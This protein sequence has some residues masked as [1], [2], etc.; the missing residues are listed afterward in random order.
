MTHWQRFLQA[1]LLL[2]NVAF[3]LFFISNPLIIQQENLTL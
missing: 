1:I 2:L 3:K